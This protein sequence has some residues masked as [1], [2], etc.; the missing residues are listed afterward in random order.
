MFKLTEANYVSF[1]RGGSTS[2]PRERDNLISMLN[3]GICKLYHILIYGTC[4]FR[5]FSLYFECLMM[6][7]PPESVEDWSN[8]MDPRWGNLDADA[9]ASARRR[10]HLA[11]CQNGK[12]KISNFLLNIIV[13]LFMLF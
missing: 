9:A 12:S 13:L 5:H 3:R 1:N 8:G 7:G 4:S 10:W 6:S 2:A 11:R